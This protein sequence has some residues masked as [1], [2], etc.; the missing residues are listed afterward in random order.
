MGFNLF[1][2]LLP[3]ELQF[4]KYMDQQALLFCETCNALNQLIIQISGLSEQEIQISVSRIKE[5]ES[6]GDNLERFI[7][8]QLDKTFIT[9]LDREDIHSLITNIDNCLDFVHS[10]AQKIEM[11]KIRS[12]PHGVLRFSEIILESSTEL[13]KLVKEMSNKGDLRRII[14]D[15]HILENEGDRLF[16]QM[17]ADL[18]AG[19]GEPMEVIKFKDLFQDMEDLLDSVDHVAKQIRGIMVKHG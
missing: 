17:T 19:G 14:R 7:T 8:A 9:P 2:L 15:I 16:H 1:D 5:L 12:V 18:F 4:F 13:K 10:V 3:R 11:Y 6:K